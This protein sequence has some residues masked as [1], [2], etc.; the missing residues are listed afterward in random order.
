M[1]LNG[2]CVGG[3]HRCANSMRS[4]LATMNFIYF[5]ILRA[6]TPDY[7]WLRRADCALWIVWKRIKWYLFM[8]ARVRVYLNSSNSCNIASITWT[9]LSPNVRNYFYYNFEFGSR[10]K[11]KIKRPPSLCVDR[12]K[13]IFFG[14]SCDRKLSRK[15]IKCQNYTRRRWWRRRRFFWHF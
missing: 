11:N 15:I 14:K 2:V 1:W 4:C 13:A 10:K 5:I 7:I 6:P 8:C 3:A 12:T 9:L